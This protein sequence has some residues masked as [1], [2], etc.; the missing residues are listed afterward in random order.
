MTHSIVTR[1]VSEGSSYAPRLRFGLLLN[2]R[3]VTVLA[4]VPNRW[5]WTRIACH[6]PAASK[7]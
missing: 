3:G 4:R 2:S 5:A 6:S 1:S 7:S